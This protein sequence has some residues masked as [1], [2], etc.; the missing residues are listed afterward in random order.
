MTSIVKRKFE[1]IHKKHRQNHFW[2]CFF[3]LFRHFWLFSGVDDWEKQVKKCSFSTHL[4]KAIDSAALNKS[5]SAHE[6]RQR[7]APYQ[8]PT[9]KIGR[10]QGSQTSNDTCASIPSKENPAY[11]HLCILKIE[12]FITRKR[13]AVFCELPQIDPET[14]LQISSVFRVGKQSNSNHLLSGFDRFKSKQ[15]LFSSP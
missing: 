6:Y 5:Q 3:N 9:T 10:L 8:A 15:L 2:R 7:F 12:K 13:M 11:I 1:K 14:A 4:S